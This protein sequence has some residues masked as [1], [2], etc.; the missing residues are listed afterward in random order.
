MCYK[1]TA[2]IA[3]TTLNAPDGWLSEAI[4]VSQG[5]TQKV[6]SICMSSNGA[7]TILGSNNKTIKLWSIVDECNAIQT[8]INHSDYVLSLDLNFD[9]TKLVSGLRDK[10]IIL[11]NFRQQW[12]CLF[13]RN[14][15]W[16]YRSYQCSEI[17]H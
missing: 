6:N 12:Y 5:H 4:D 2:T 11:Q 16:S 3:P 8:L 15:G 10:T 14:P 17:L 9:G 7:W 13:Q 1:F